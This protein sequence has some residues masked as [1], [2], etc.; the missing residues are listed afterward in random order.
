MS[1]YFSAYKWR[2]LRE[3]VPAVAEAAA[4]GRCMLGT[5]DTWLLYQLTGGAEGALP[6]WLSCGRAC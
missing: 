2:W 1:T 6:P 3:N 4:Q 5:I